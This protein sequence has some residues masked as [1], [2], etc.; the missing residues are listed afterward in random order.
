MAALVDA[1]QVVQVVHSCSCSSSVSIHVHQ[2][3]V[4]VI[5]LQAHLRII[6]KVRAHTHGGWIVVVRML[7]AQMAAPFGSIDR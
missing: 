2:L 6:C 7:E 1:G 4:I 3:F 5:I